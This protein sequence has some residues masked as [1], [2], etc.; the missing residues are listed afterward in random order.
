LPFTPSFAFYYNHDKEIAAAHK[1]FQAASGAENLDGIPSAE[2][3][4]YLSL[5]IIGRIKGLERLAL[6]R[7]LHGVYSVDF[8][9]CLIFLQVK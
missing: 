7:G 3:S 5:S 1:I 2:R 8:T 4:A 9:T 6:T